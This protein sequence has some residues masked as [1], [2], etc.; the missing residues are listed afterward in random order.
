MAIVQI[1]RIQHRRGLKEQLP[2]LSAGELGWAVDTQEL[3]IGNGTLSDGAPEVG[4]TKILTEDD[5]LLS[6][7]NTYTYRGNTTSPVVT[8][9]D[10]NSPVVR[11]LQQKLDDWASVKDFGAKGD[12]TTD[13]TAAINRALANLYTVNYGSFT[14][15]RVLYF[16]GGKYKVTDTIKI[17][18]HVT[19]LGDGPTSTILESN[20][21]T[22]DWA[23][24]F[25]D[26]NGNTRSDIGSGGAD[27]PEGISINGICFKTLYD[28][29]IMR[30]DQ[31]SSMRFHDCHWLGIYAQEDGVTN[32][33]A[34]VEVFS[35]SALQ[36]KR[37]DF[38][39]CIFEGSENLIKISEDVQD[40]AIS[41]SEFLKANIGINL[42]EETD[43]STS[44][45]I[46]GPQGISVSSSRFD[47]IDAQAVIVYNNGGS[48]HGN[49][50]SSCSFRDVG[51]GGI[52]SS[53][54]AAI[55]FLH[56]NNFAFGNYFHRLPHFERSSYEG[57]VY[58]ESPVDHPITL[59]DGASGATMTDAVEA[60]AVRHD[61]QRENHVVYD[62]IIERNTARRTGKLTIS[63]T[64]SS[65]CYSDDF[66]EN[67][68]TGVTITVD[69][70]GILKYSTTSTGNTA[71]FKYRVLRFI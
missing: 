6:V 64:A 36:T 1:S 44:N 9:V 24:E 31:A 59:N 33:Y 28:Q 23:F 54:T 20:D 40:I 11:T 22:T 70:N 43:G 15:R 65:F 14:E 69:S 49:I 35:T 26:S 68:S 47:D 46:I 8:G 7:A 71:T 18:P 53:V 19:L 10:S 41:S 38:L 12:G 16:P 61:L 52:D 13:D 67:E 25:V 51:S 37:I 56:A 21:A 50:V 55:S 27:R 62:Y 30:I 42:G 39:G 60:E 32:G 5:N 34:G 63:G 45:K 2:Q 57:S 17:Y 3:Y 29:N 66:V 58:S 48:P 4:N